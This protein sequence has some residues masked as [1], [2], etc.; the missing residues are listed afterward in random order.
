MMMMT[1]DDSN[2]DDGDSSVIN[3]KETVQQRSCSGIVHISWKNGGRNVLKSISSNGAV[4]MWKVEGS[5]LT[6]KGSFLLKSDDHQTIISCKKDRMKSDIRN[7]LFRLRCLDIN[8][9]EDDGD[10]AAWVAA[11]D[12]LTLC[13]L[14]TQQILW[15]SPP[16]RS[17][18]STISGGGYLP[19]VIIRR[20]PVVG[21]N[22]CLT[23]SLDWHIYM[24]N[25][26][27]THS[28]YIKRWDIGSEATDVQFAPGS[29]DIFAVTTAT[30]VVKIFNLA[31]DPNQPVCSQKVVGRKRRLTRVMFSPYR[32]MIVV[33]DDHGGVSF[34]K[35]PPTLTTGSTGSDPSSAK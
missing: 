10:T 4:A 7:S 14:T 35:L 17:T 1:N 15:Q 21:S 34:L 25:T 26:A 16:L 31:V 3:S 9:G 33:G 12:T 2:H 19:H 5:K 23:L 27:I 29:R 30:G 20:C 11:S 13:S 8:D 6:A 28:S 18:T 24:W 22:L 32:P